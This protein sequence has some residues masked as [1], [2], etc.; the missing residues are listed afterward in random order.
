VREEPFCI[1]RNRRRGAISDCRCNQFCDVQC[2][3]R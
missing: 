3:N 1:Y 2:S